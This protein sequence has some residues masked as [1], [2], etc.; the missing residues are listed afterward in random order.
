MQ[1]YTIEGRYTALALIR[2]NADGSFLRIDGGKQVSFTE[3]WKDATVKT[4]AQID[5]HFKNNDAAL[6]MLTGEKNG[7]TVIDFDTKDNDLFLELY[8]EAPTFCVETEKGFHLYYQYSTDPMFV[9]RAG[10]FNGGV[11]V[12]NDGGLIFCPP[13]PNYK[14]FNEENINPF[15]ETGLILL[16]KSFTPSGGKTRGNLSE[17][18]TRNDSLFRY[19]CKW[20]NE[21]TKQETW[22]KMVQANNAFKKGK[23]DEKEL[24][25]L[26]QQILKYSPEVKEEEP[27]NEGV[28][29]ASLGLLTVGEDGKEVYNNNE[30]NIV[31]LLKKHPAFA[32]RFRLNVWN[33]REEVEEGG[34]WRD[35]ED[36]DITFTLRKISVLYPQFR[37]VKKLTVQD[38]IVDVCKENPYDPVVSYVRS[39]QWDGIERISS[40]LQEVYGVEDNE[41]HQKVGGNFFKGMIQ[42]ILYPGC[43]VD[44]VLLLEGEQGCGKSSSLGVIGGAWHL[45]TTMAADSKDFFMQFRGK[46]IVEFS[47]GETQRRTETMKMK[48]IISTAVDTYRAPYG[49]AMRDIPRRCVFA[50][51]T[52]SDESLKDLTGNRRFFPVVVERNVDLEWLR[53]NRDQL[54]AE[55]LHGVETLKEKSYEYPLEYAERLRN[56]KMERSGLEGIVSEWLNAPRKF[57]GEVIDVSDGV[58]NEDVWLYALN[59]AKDRYNKREEMRIAQTLRGLG[60]QKGRKQV[61]GI[62]KIRWNKP[63]CP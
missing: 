7:I 13:T 3:N 63:C 45:E 14:I 41:Y 39:T 2:R 25:T 12:R 38:A 32:N 19:G 17:T 6:G 56:E 10:V 16:R 57:N 42:R 29:I 21:Y 50:M 60:Y 18:E 47:E 51:T 24:E 58:T 48:A 26:Y 30:E 33:E 54:F 37:M 27:D 11:D 59:G 23:L 20:I 46:L 62:E 34:V 4:K 9:N 53:E 35:L 1:K 61:G 40:W 8:S 28:P 44:S 36:T 15:T 52:N 43:K 31:R 22:M 55:A 5:K 49:R